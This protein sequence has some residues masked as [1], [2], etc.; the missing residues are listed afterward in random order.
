MVLALDERAR[1]RDGVAQEELALVEHQLVERV[2]E[3]GLGRQRAER[4][5]ARQPEAADEVV[6]VELGQVIVVGAEERR[7]DRGLPVL[8]AEPRVPRVEARQ[9]ARRLV[10]PLPELPDERLARGQIRDDRDV[11][12]EEESEPDVEGEPSLPAP[13]DRQPLAEALGGSGQGRAWGQPERLLHLGGR[14][15]RGSER[16]EGQARVE[17]GELLDVRILRGPGP[18]G[19]ERTPVVLLPVPDEADVVAEAVPLR[20]GAERLIQERPGA[21]VLLLREV[22]EAQL[23]RD[24]DVCRCESV[25]AL[26]GRDRRGWPASGH[27]HDARV[28]EGLDVVGLDLEGPAEVGERVVVA[29]VVEVDDG[30]GDEDVRL[31]R[32]GARARGGGRAE[33]DQDRHDGPRRGPARAQEGS[34]CRRFLQTRAGRTTTVGPAP[35]RRRRGRRTSG[36]AR[37][38]RLRSYRCRWPASG[39]KS[40]SQV[41][42]LPRVSRATSNSATN[43]PLRRKTWI[44]LWLRSQT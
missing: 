17:A 15:S 20:V 38:Y 27:L 25:R 42:P 28:V 18:E 24:G 6:D 23:E 8:R 11:V 34:H 22:G 31:A 41:E 37:R 33:Q 40:T 32:L 10:R 3:P 43:S 21:V 16:A 1:E 29:L 7:A 4:Q 12:V 9:F 19:G 13:G 36:P 30:L 35:A 2:L 44:R 39:E 14:L 26:E 5:F